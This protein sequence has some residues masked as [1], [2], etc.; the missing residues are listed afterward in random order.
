MTPFR[1]IRLDRLAGIAAVLALHA[2]ALH[3]LWSHRIQVRPD[4]VVTLFVDTITPPKEESPQPAPQPPRPKKPRPA[5]TPRQLAAPAPAP[6][7]VE[8]VAPPPSPAPAVEAPPARPAG[9]VTLGIEL[10]LS[11]PERSAPA[12]P[13]LSRRLGEEGKV[14]LRVELDEQGGVAAARV[15]ASSGYARLDEAAL[16]AVKAWRCTPARRDGQPV[17]AVA[18]QPFMFVLQ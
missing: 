12:Y 13:S 6:S 11:C 7:P 1:T 8:S 4:E 5:E 17:R 2:V 9:P 16:A 3:G 14:V 15:A 18:M 10:A